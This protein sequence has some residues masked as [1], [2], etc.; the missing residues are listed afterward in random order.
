MAARGLSIL[1]LVALGLGA[2]GYAGFLAFSDSD[3]LPGLTEDRMLSAAVAGVVGAVSL[4]IALVVAFAAKPR[5][6]P[7]APG[8]AAAAPEVVVIKR[9]AMD[10]GEPAPRPAEDL[11]GRLEEIDQ[12][13][14]RLKVEYGTGQLSSEG[15]KALVNDLE[16]EKVRLERARHQ[17]A[18]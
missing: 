12:R 4:L 2:A 14:G 3:A 11:E 16:A 7:P 13:L 17:R 15:Y 5:A 18:G 9:T 6:P 10:W 8:P 1:L